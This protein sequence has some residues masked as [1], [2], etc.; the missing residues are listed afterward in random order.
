LKSFN[1]NM[2]LKGF[3]LRRFSLVFVTDIIDLFVLTFLDILLTLRWELLGP[4]V[5]YC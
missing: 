1:Q 4:G 5:I 3:L 2:S